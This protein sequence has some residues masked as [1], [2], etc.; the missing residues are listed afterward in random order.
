MKQFIELTH[1][2]QLVSI[3][4]DPYVIIGLMRHQDDGKSILILRGGSEIQVL[5]P[6]TEISVKMEKFFEDDKFNYATIKNSL[7]QEPK[8]EP[9]AE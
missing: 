7:E 1:A 3:F 5:E 6:L 2:A 8:P 4:I 9:K